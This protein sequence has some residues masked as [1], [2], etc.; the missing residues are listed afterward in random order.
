MASPSSVI[1][2]AKRPPLCATAPVLN[3]LLPLVAGI[4]AARAL[5]EVWIYPILPAL[6]AA[7][8]LRRSGPVLVAVMSFLAGLFLMQRVI[9]PPDPLWRELPPREVRMELRIDE[10]FNARKPGRIAGTGTIQRSGIPHDTVRGRRAAFYLESGPMGER[11]PVAGEAVEC[12]AVLT[13]LPRLE[14]HDDYQAYLLGRDIF[15]TLNRGEVLR[16]A[17]PP[18]QS[19]QRRHRLYR[20]FQDILTT[21]CQSPEDP[22]LVLASMLLGNRSLLNDERIGLYRRTGTYH[23]FAVSGLHVGSIAL[24]L[25][26]LCGLAR[27]PA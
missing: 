25:H 11:P 26:L 14:E 6:G 2:P 15:L 1:D 16:L 4:L 17:R 23:L 22:G 27:L 13:Y 10:V 3:S 24:C 19:E 12:R 21:G 8:A 18:P 20:K 5:P 7:V 9:E